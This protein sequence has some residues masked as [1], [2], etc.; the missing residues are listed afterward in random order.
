MSKLSIKKGDK[1]VVIAGKELGKT[2]TV[3]DCFP[4]ENK[5]TL[6]E[7]NIIVKHNKPRSAQ[8]K[9]GIVKKEGKIDASNVMV[10]CPACDKATRVS[11]SKNQKGEKIRIC[12]KCGASLDS[13]V[14]K[15]AAAKKTAESAKASS[16]KPAEKVAEK[17]PAK[18]ASEKKLTVKD[19]KNLEASKKATKTVKAASTVKKA[20]N[21]AKKIGGK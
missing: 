17:A 16:E 8:D 5:V 15:P 13:G 4:D 20:T 14:K 2:S 12:K 6:K 9:G 3:V 10:V 19:T 18:K 21:T 1:V 7:L 11:Y